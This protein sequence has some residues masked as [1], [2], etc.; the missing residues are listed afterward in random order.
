ML[1]VGLE[2]G[3]DM[4]GLGIWLGIRLGVRGSGLG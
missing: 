4:L 3:L 2:L 1:G